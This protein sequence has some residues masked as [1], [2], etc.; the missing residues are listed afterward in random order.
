LGLQ[1]LQQPI[2]QGQTLL[3]SSV[4]GPW[5]VNANSENPLRREPGV[6][7]IELEEA[8]HHEARADQQNIGEG[9]LRCDER[10]TQHRAAFLR[11]GPAALLQ[12]VSHVVPREQGRHGTEHDG[13]GAGT[14]QGER[15]HPAVN[16]DLSRAR[17]EL[18]R[19]LRQQSQAARRQ[20]Q[21][22]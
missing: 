15:Q 19:K 21:P 9:H 13:G 1:F 14:K 12:A 20:Q 11:T 16:A 5:R 4:L 6:D 8:A 2:G 17:R 7:A 18:T 3:P 10:L 22:D